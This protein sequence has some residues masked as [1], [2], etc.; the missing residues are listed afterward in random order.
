MSSK[1]AGAT[2]SIFEGKGR[3]GTK[4]VLEAGFMHWI[5]QKTKHLGGTNMPGEEDP[6]AQGKGQAAELFWF[7]TKHSRG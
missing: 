3:R 5:H 2:K 1:D 4:T 7:R 6:H